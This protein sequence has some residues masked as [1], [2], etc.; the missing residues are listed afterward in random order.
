MNIVPSDIFLR[1]ISFLFGTDLEHYEIMAQAFLFFLAG[2]ETTANTL[3]F[4]LYHLAVN[5]ECQEK[6]YEE[7]M[8]VFGEVSIQ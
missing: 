3:S 2:Y 5:Q 8:D 6:A 4:A 7:I 1:G